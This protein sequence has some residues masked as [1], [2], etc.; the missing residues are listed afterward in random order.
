MKL[1]ILILFFGFLISDFTL[2]DC[3]INTDHEKHPRLDDVSSTW[4][5]LSE[6]P[7]C[8]II[9]MNLSDYWSS[10]DSIDII[11]FNFQFDQGHHGISKSTIGICYRNI[12]N[13]I[14]SCAKSA[15]P[16]PN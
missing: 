1:P 13:G 3:S 10:K 12:G 4:K 2:A 6:N 8:K 9:R 5:Y 15:M 14:I 7:D 11:L 16:E